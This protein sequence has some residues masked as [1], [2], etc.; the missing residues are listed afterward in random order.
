VLVEIGAVDAHP[1]LVRV[2]LAN[3]DGIGE[4]LRMETSR[5]KPGASSLASSFLMASR[6]LSA[7]RRRC[8]LLGVALGSMLSECSINLLGT[9][10]MSA[11]FHAKMSQLA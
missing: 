3:E 5:M 6:W 8:C 7:K 4:P 11:G 2:L 9:R 1:P 10:G